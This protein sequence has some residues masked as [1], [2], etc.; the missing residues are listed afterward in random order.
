MIDLYISRM[1]F[2]VTVKKLKF[3]FDL[4]TCWLLCTWYEQYNTFVAIFQA[5]K[6]SFYGTVYFVLSFSMFASILMFPDEVKNG[7]I[8][9]KPNQAYETVSLPSPS[10]P[11]TQVSTKPCPAYEVVVITEG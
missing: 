3:V 8:E 5:E 4:C 10:K 9:M 11:A 6:K 1:P 7:E 2:Y